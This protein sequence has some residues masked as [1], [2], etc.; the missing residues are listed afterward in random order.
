MVLT[1]EG[2]GRGERGLW[3]VIFFQ[4]VEMWKS[5]KSN[6][7]GWKE[8]RRKMV[9]WQPESTLYFPFAAFINEP[10]RVLKLRIALQ[11]LKSPAWREEGCHVT[12]GEKCEIRPLIL[13]LSI[14]REEWKR[15]RIREWNN[16]SWK[17]REMNEEPWKRRI[18]RRGA[19]FI[20]FSSLLHNNMCPIESMEGEIQDRTLSLPRPCFSFIS[21][22]QHFI[23]N[24]LTQLFH[25]L[26]VVCVIHKMKKR[27]EKLKGE[28]NFQK[29][30]FIS[31]N[32]SSRSRSHPSFPFFIHSFIHF[33][34]P[35]ILYFLYFLNSVSCSS[36]GQ[37][38]EGWQC[39]IRF[40]GIIYGR[41]KIHT[42]HTKKNRIMGRERRTQR[43]KDGWMDGRK[44]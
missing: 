15:Y 8:K 22:L 17:R 32:P 13:N 21:V 36:S 16:E 30:L 42:T 7:K 44:K 27:G 38:E 28:C 18:R 10:K 34:Y 12:R 29:L 43:V 1:S 39:L 40:I 26:P 6:K 35:F 25:L 11:L 41:V 33:H 20:F 31:F 4:K 24:S 5:W 2:K 3:V 23:Y 9:S 14:H 19:L 37:G